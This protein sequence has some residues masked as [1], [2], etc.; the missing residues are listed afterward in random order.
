MV[1]RYLILTRGRKLFNSDIYM[2]HEENLCNI[3]QSIALDGVSP[4]EWNKKKKKYD[5]VTR[6][7]KRVVE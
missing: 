5:V 7:V 2:T 6:D 1:K 3:M 4:R